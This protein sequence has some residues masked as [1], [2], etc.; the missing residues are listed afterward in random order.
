MW[1][2]KYVPETKTWLSLQFYTSRRS[3]IFPDQKYQTSGGEGRLYEIIKDITQA[4][5]VRYV[6]Y[7]IDF[8]FSSSLTPGKAIFNH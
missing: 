3:D 7:T 4:C 8:R 2:K 1:D 5:G 6:H